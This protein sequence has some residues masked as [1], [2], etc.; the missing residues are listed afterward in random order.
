M[1]HW[2]NMG[3]F[4]HQQEG[5]RWAQVRGRRCGL[6]LQQEQPGLCLLLILQAGSFDW[7]LELC[8]HTLPQRA[9]PMTRP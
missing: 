6:H 7:H 5:G 3:S 8:A 4:L 9:G 2:K 1:T